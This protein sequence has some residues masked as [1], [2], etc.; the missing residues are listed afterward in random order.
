V[1]PSIH[2]DLLAPEVIANPYPYLAHL[3][4]TDPVHWNALHEISVITRYDDFVWIMRQPELFSSEVVRRSLPP[5]DL[6]GPAADR[7]LHDKARHIQANSLAQRDYDEH[8]AMR[9]VLQAYFTPHAVERWRP[10]LQE[11]L[12]ELLDRV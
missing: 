4:E 8:R 2:D 12:G 6:S 3:R 5:S 10:R 1:V 9:Q 7:E 11:I